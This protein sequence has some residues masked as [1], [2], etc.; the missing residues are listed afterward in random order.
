MNRCRPWIDLD[1]LNRITISG[2][3][4]IKSFDA[5]QTLRETWDPSV[6]HMEQAGGQ[7]DAEAKTPTIVAFRHG[8]LALESWDVSLGRMVVKISPG[9][10]MYSGLASGYSIS[11]EL[12]NGAA[13][14]DARTIEISASG[15]VD[16]APLATISPAGA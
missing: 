13:E 12:E 9:R 1:D 11:F 7:G 16:G 3:L 5:E 2:L 8:V 6:Q 4:G 10:L 14:Q 15:A